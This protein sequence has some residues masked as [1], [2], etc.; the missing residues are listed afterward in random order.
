MNRLVIALVTTT[1]GA[2]L[3]CSGKG[4]SSAEGPGSA[5]PP[6]LAKRLSI[7]WGL[8][9]ASRGGRAMTEVYLAMTDET[10]KQTSHS[11]GT[12]EG[13]CAVFSPPAEMRALTGV[14]CDTGGAGT[15]LHAIVQGGD[16]IVILHGLWAEGATPDPMGREEVT[17]FKVPLGVAISV[18]PVAA[19]TGAP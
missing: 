9:P 12:Y 16:Q 1:L 10:A 13:A 18:D 5:A 17:R 11:I 2:G 8:T 6:P 15:D 19:T 7:S 4:K 3:G 14:R